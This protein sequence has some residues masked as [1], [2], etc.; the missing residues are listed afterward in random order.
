MP[1]RVYKRKPK[2][3]NPYAKSRLYLFRRRYMKSIASPNHVYSHIVRTTPYQITNT[4]ITGTTGCISF[5]LADVVNVAEFTVLYDSYRVNYLKIKIIPWFNS[6][7]QGN[8]ISVVGSNWQPYLITCIDFDDTTPDSYA[9]LLERSN[10][11]FNRLGKV[12]NFGFVPHL[13]IPASSGT[14]NIK[15]NTRWLDV[16]VTTDVHMGLKYFL[17]DANTGAAQMAT[18]IIEAQVD[19]RCAR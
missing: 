15:S 2:V 18:V 19:F 4:A 13:N 5:R 1:R 12:L 7:D 3:K 14:S 16:A 17:S 6:V 10:A 9:Q 11:K 8:L